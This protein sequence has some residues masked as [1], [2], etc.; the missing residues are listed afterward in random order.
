[1]RVLL[2]SASAKFV[3]KHTYTDNTQ[4][5]AHSLPLAGPNPAANYAN[6]GN[7][8]LKVCCIDSWPL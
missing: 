5:D 6:G 7:K 1:M 2:C 4:H 8:C 3:R